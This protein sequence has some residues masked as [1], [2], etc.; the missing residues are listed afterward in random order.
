MNIAFY[1]PLKA[2]TAENPSGDRL[3]GQQLIRALQ[4]VG[5]DVDLVSTFRSYDGSGDADRQSRL[6]H[7]GGRIANRLVRRLESRTPD[8]WF[9]YHLYH[10][11]PDWIGPTVA[12]AFKIPYVVAEASFAPKQGHGPWAQGHAAVQQAL[13]KVSLVIG[14]T[15]TDRTCVEPQLS[16]K[17][18][19]LQLSPFLDTESYVAA[20]DQR[21]HLRRKLV[22]ERGLNPSVPWLLAVAMMRPG[23]KTESYE[24]LAQALTE[25]GDREWQLLVAGDGVMRGHV[26]SSF[27]AVTERVIWLGCQQ[28]ASLAELYAASDIFVWPAVKE[29]P[30]MCFLEAG[31]AGL[32]VVGGNGFGVA[33]VVV[34]GK[35]GLLATHLSVPDFADKVRMLL[36]NLSLRR[37]MGAHALEHVRQNH[38]VGVAGTIMDTALAE[39]IS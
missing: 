27:G 6:K 35:T 19:Y 9:T 15:E 32:P 36:D 28:P 5:H 13:A 17:S 25:I 37:E 14:L 1:A 24:I 33:D 31:A 12:H 30:G 34:D 16:E 20:A 10:K 2:P 7:L 3:I 21:D 29:T 38:D 18:G 39:L 11:A 4:A 8:I 23:D 26:E 22:E